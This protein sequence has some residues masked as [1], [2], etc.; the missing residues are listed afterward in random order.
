MTA[1]KQNKI[2]TMPAHLTRIY[3]YKNH[4]PYLLGHDNQQDSRSD[5]PSLLSAGLQFVSSALLHLKPGVVHIQS[6]SALLCRSLK[7]CHC[8]HLLS[9]T[10]VNSD[11]QFQPHNEVCCYVCS[12]MKFLF[13]Q[14]ASYPTS[15]V[16]LLLGMLCIST[17]G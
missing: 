11:E 13:V 10:V 16:I 7:P 3:M 8:A 5:E 2:T 6:G 4:L 12:R 15:R 9:A 14:A 17:A 1:T